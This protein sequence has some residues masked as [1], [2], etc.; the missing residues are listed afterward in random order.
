VLVVAGLVA[1]I[2]MVNR[3]GDEEGI[4]SDDS[5]GYLVAGTLPDGWQLQEVRTLRSTD[6]GNGMRGTIDVYGDGSL[7]DPWAGP[8]LSVLR[9][10]D[11]LGAGP[12]DAETTEIG[13]RPARISEEPD[14]VR[15][16]VDDGLVGITAR[17]LDRDAAVA[18]AEAVVAGLPDGFER[19]ASGPLSAATVSSGFT[20]DGLAL[21]YGG[22]TS[23]EQLAVIQ[24]AGDADDAELIRLMGPDVQVTEVQGQPAYLVGGYLLQWY[25]PGAGALVTVLAGGQSDEVM[26]EFAESLRPAQPGEVDD[27][28]RSHGVSG[29]FGRL[30]PGEVL[31]A[32]GEYGPDDPWRLVASDDASEGFG[33]TLSDTAGSTG[34]GVGRDEGWGTLSVDVAA[35]A[36]AA[37]HDR[38]AVYGAVD[39]AADTVV[40]EL[41]GGSPLPLDLHT[42]DGIPGWDEKV[43]VGLVPP[44]LGPATVVA[45]DAA[46]NEL[47]RTPLDVGV[48]GSSVGGGSSSGTASGGS[49]SGGSSSESC[50]SLPDGG[51]E[52]VSSSAATTAPPPGG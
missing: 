5:P 23:D 1:A 36:T 7:D 25:D 51:E 45:R 29:P 27:L 26:T 47:A 39:A 50:R 46:G 42:V 49:S 2:V 30:Q 8:T 22:A 21:I 14:G 31:V 9:A 40:V 33:L 12:T 13:G 28:V 24:R 16:T 38:V 41:P 4:T 35:H 52:C 34:T 15:I 18:F 17:Y 10:A 19:L 20:V 3:S 43:F 32:E 37:E 6:V 44:D 48:G 11:D